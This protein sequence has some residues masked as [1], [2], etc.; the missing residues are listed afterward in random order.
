MNWFINSV[1]ELFLNFHDQLT[2]LLPLTEYP[3][4]I[5]FSAAG[6]QTKG[7]R[8]LNLSAE[9]LSNLSITRMRHFDRNFRGEASAEAKNVERRNPVQR[10]STIRGIDYRFV[11]FLHCAIPRKAGKLGSK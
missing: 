3:N 11:R 8:N 2:W 1:S 10:A 7:V 4:V 6:L 9:T 5:A